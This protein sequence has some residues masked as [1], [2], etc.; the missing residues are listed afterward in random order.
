MKSLYKTLAIAVF[1]TA[2]AW[3]TMQAQ[4]WVTLPGNFQ[5]ELGCAGD[6]NPACDITGLTFNGGTGMWEGSFNIPAGNWEYK[7]AIDHAWNENYGAGGIP[8]GSNIG[9]NLAVPT[10]V[11]FSYNPIT[12]IVVN[13]VATGMV[14]LAG[15]FQSEL[16]CSSDWNPACGL[17]QLL[18][19]GATNTWQNSYWLP[20]G[21]WEYRAALNGSWSENY[22]QGGSPGGANYQLHLSQYTQMGFSYNPITHIV[23]A[24]PVPWAV[25]LAGSFQSEMGCPGDWQPDCA[26]T[27]LWFDPSLLL[28]K[29]S[30]EMPPG[31]FEFKITHNYSWG[32]NYGQGG[33][34]GGPNIP[35]SL[36]GPSLVDFTYDPFTHIINIQA[37]PYTVVIPGSFGEELGCPTLPGYGSGDW[38]PACDNA[39]LTYETTTNTWARTLS[40]PKGDWEYKVTINDSW[41]RNYG[42][43]GYRDGANIPLSLPLAADV[44]FRYNPVNHLVTLSYPHPYIIV[45]KFY[46]LNLNGRNDDGMPLANVEFKLDST[47]TATE[48]TDADG[49]ILFGNLNKG[50]YKIT[51]TMPAGYLTTSANPWYIELEQPVTLPFGNVC[52]GGGN[53]KGIGYWA[54]KHGAATLEELGK[55]DWVLYNLRGLSLR[56]ADGSQFDPNT[57]GEVQAWLQRANGKNMA[58]MLSAQMVA[59]RLNMETGFV[60]YFDGMYAPGYGNLGYYHDFVVVG[61]LLQKAGW[62]LES[63]GYTPAGHPNR[64]FQESMK[65]VFEKGNNNM[66]FVQKT[67]CAIAESLITQTSTNPL[68]IQQSKADKPTYNVWPNPSNGS[69][70][71][72]SKTGSHQKPLHIAVYDARGRVIYKA[73]G[74][75]VKDLR[76]GQDFAPGLYMV[77]IMQGN[78]QN[79]LKLL[80]Q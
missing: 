57:Y 50:E 70:T 5:S 17:S 25:V 44:T 7:V 31:D 40:L 51:E 14:V 19:N 61:F 29:G 58:Y 73:D 69:F 66:I 37:V 36:S 30:Y 65:D 47:M 15:N 28:W 12:H 63:D 53:A 54:G 26:N 74:S 55:T 6:W 4:T 22:G 10:L 20:P 24:A 71:L 52:L 67:P 77:R 72:Q 78:E 46:D 2:S 62:A 43:G 27:G 80:K 34:P 3:Q 45:E 42:A 23:Y 33:V 49:K 16:G 18:F 59:M 21:N 68:L 1:L 8:G 9:L 35:L 75:T 56:N 41:S 32:E 39:R 64:M 38:N 48:Y 13:S 79:T 76:F 60:D 11:H